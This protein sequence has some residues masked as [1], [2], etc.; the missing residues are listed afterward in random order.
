MLTC[1]H[2]PAP[3]GSSLLWEMLLETQARAFSSRVRCCDGP[4][5]SLSLSRCFFVDF[6][7]CAVVYIVFRWIL[8]FLPSRTSMA[9]LT[10]GSV[11]RIVESSRSGES[12]PLNPVLQVTA[13]KCLNPGTGQARHRLVLS[14]GQHTVQGM[15]ATQHNI[16]VTSGELKDFDI[17]RLTEYICNSVQNRQI[18]ILLGFNVIVKHGAQIGNPTTVE[19]ASAGAVPKPQIRQ[20]PVSQPQS[21]HH[22]QAHRADPNQRIMPI[23]GINPYSNKWV[24][25]AR[26]TSKGTVR[27]WNK[28]PGN[29]GKLFSCNLVD[30]EGSEIRATFFKEAVDKFNEVLQVDGVYTFTNGRAKIANRKFSNLDATYEL[31]F[32][33]D[34]VV[35]PCSDDKSIKRIQLKRVMIGDIQNVQP[36]DNVDVVGV[37]TLTGE[38]VNITSKAGR[39]LTKCD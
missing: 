14:D 7:P 21:F 30:N 22:Q 8:F 13:I 26:V 16:K 15:L 29:V 38:V 9:T 37:V 35:M 27:H 11:L 5:F 36:N 31:N 3:F 23:R 17:I 39:E 2:L 25:K 34:A 4:S 20:P 18:V 19:E 12:Q 1:D 32:G 6:S 28:G 10:Q 33:R 24:I